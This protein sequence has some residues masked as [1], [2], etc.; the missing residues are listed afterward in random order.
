MEGKQ[1]INTVVVQFVFK[2]HTLCANYFTDECKDLADCHQCIASECSWELD[3]GTCHK[4]FGGP[5]PFLMTGQGRQCPDVSTC[6]V[7]WYQGKSV[8]YKCI[9]FTVKKLDLDFF[10]FASI[11]H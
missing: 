9:S 1:L 11:F 2:S 7:G 5:G 4:T 8:F 6:Y 10:D 3:R